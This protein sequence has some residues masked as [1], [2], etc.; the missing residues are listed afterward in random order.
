QELTKQLINHRNNKMKCNQWTLG[1]AALGVIS[2][3]SVA[4]A[5]EAKMSSVQTAVASTT[6]SGFVDTSAQWNIG[7][8]KTHAPGY[9]FGGAGKA[10]GFNL[11]VVDLNLQ[12][13]P[14]ASDNW[15]AGY[16][17]ELWAGPDA[18]AFATQSTGVGTDFAIKNAYVD[19]K[20]PV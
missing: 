16:R 4:R 18:V 5:E 12:K 15:G 20:A 2:L 19:L 11:N 1:L 9:T 14:D 3:A 17:V 7:T 6:L 8:A 10:D 13:D